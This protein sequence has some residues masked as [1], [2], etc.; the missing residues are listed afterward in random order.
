MRAGMPAET[1]AG[2]YMRARETGKRREKN[3]S[4]TGSRVPTGT[5]EAH[6]TRDGIRWDKRSKRDGD[7]KSGG[8]QRELFFSSQT[9][10]EITSGIGIDRTPVQSSHAN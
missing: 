5:R 1:H 4:R 8:S 2:L 3:S 9:K 10:K 7:R 6:S